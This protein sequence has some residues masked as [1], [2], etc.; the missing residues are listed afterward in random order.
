M[1]SV[2]KLIR[3]IPDW[4]QKGI[5]FKDIT[6]LVRSPQGLNSLVEGFER[7]CEGWDID[8]VAGVEARGFL[9]APILAWK[10]GKGLIPIR[11]KGKLPFRTIGRDYQLEYG[12]NSLEIHT[13]A[14]EKGQRVLL[15]DDLL[16]T[17][18]T[19]LAA[20]EL[21]EE[22]GGI[23]SAAGFVVCLSYLDGKNVLAQKGIPHFSLIEY[24]S[25]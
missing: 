7:C 20:A 18:G 19:A 14:L 11:K 6:P 3:E 21:I 10:L 8:M 13:D 23:V 1:E 22:V 9:L 5:L 4:P 2:R 17:G 25:Q 16:A 24:S 12:T 15:V